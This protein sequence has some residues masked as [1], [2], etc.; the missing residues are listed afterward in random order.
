MPPNRRD[1]KGPARTIETL[2]VYRS[3]M[4]T[5]DASCLHEKLLNDHVHRI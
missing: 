1:M 3:V 4:K 5:F 2:S